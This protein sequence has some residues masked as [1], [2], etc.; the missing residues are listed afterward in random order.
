MIAMMAVAVM[1]IQ[2][3]VALTN[4]LNSIIATTKN[5]V[6]SDVRQIKIWIFGTTSATWQ[7]HGQAAAKNHPL[8]GH[9]LIKQSWAHRLHPAQLPHHSRKPAYR[10]ASVSSYRL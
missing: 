6:V 4:A 1:T 3:S 7:S 2:G 10:H 8:E 9:F 5:W